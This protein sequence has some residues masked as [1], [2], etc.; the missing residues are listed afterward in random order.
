VGLT[1]VSLAVTVLR[2]SADSPGML[3]AYVG[4]VVGIVGVGVVLAFAGTR[5]FGRLP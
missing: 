3:V 2:A 5:L 1:G 4:G